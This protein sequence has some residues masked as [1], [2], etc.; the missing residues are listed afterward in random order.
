MAQ[1]TLPDVLAAVY[2]DPTRV[3]RGPE[4]EEISQLVRQ[5][6]EKPAEVLADLLKTRRRAAKAERNCAQAA[7]A[8]TNLEQMLKNLLDGHASHYRMES[9]RREGDAVWVVCRVGN[10]LREY[11]IHPDVD[12]A[13]LEALEPWEY[14]RVR[15]EVVVGVWAG[16]P[17]LFMAAHG[18]VASFK[19]VCDADLGLI[20]VQQ[21]GQ[22]DSVVR[23]ARRLRD[24][25]LV[26]TSRL[27]LLRD[28]PRWAV[29]MIPSQAAQSRFEAPIEHITTRLEDL[30]GI[31]AIAS[32]L[33][34]DVLVHVIHPAVRQEFG[35]EAMHGFL[36]SS[37]QPGMGKTAF[38]RGFARWLYELGQQIGLDVVLYVVPPNAF[39]SM[40]HGE[41]ARIVREDLW[42]AIRARQLLPRQR[43]LVQFVVLDE[44][45][46]LG[47]RSDASHG[48]T[49]S[50]QSDAL[51]A[52]LAEMDGM[53]SR[54]AVQEP[55]VYV[56]FGG[57]TNLPDRV[58]EALK[59][60]GRLGDL[61]LEMPPIDIEGAEDILAIYARGPL[62]WYCFDR[63]H[64]DV[65]ADF[66][67][68][69]FL[70]PALAAV[71]PTVVLY[72]TTD[73]QR[74]IDVTAGEILAGVHYEQAMNEA[75]KRAALRRLRRIGVP[76]VAFDDLVDCL[77]DV[78]NDV[79][80][81]MQADPHMLIR[82]LQVKVAVARV[83][84][85]DKQQL[86]KHR[87]LKLH[88]A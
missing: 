17:S 13:R 84:A 1:L 58:D 59:R 83:E 12:V 67:R 81:Q 66:V 63:I 87:F 79:A 16:D 18:S 9:L 30:A 88:G 23:L 35:L 54:T 86:Q 4:L 56:L 45:D 39:K 62:A 51:E 47:K 80:R 55:P 70:R 27:V 19:N 44:V 48:I 40:W 75:K 53:I 14:V 78:A 49:S 60:V 85:V 24:Q 29:A 22:G 10:M 77:L 20:Q 82:Q 34:E 2:G 25:K 11:P 68:S 33:I 31:D 7:E 69:Q 52:M 41:D 38:M 21:D 73:Q 32:R 37:Y 46:S 74:R 50:A 3:P 6:G 43:P 5:H 64:R 26:P 57:T 72:Y 42:G 65:D 71:F 28:D 61:S 15:E 76:A 36:L 8:A